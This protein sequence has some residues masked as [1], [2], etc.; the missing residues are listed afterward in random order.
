MMRKYIIREDTVNRV[1]EALKSNKEV[2]HDF[3]TGL[4]ILS[5]YMPSHLDQ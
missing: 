2:L 4:C 3:D 5:P 1:Q